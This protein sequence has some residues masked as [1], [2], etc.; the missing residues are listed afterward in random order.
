[1]SMKQ[2]ISW[3]SVLLWMSLIY[4]LS[5]Q[6]AA[7][8]TELSTGVMQVLIASFE[9]IFLFIN[10][11]TEWFHFLIRKGAHFTAYFILGILLINALR[12]SK[13][14]DTSAMIALLLSVLYAISDEVHQLFIPGRSGEVRDVLIDSA[15]A[16]VGISLYYLLAKIKAK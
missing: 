3:L 12:K 7:E 6:P 1:M 10:L 14:V 15:G 13:A 4:Y 2:V 11:E 5:H 8:S 9:A 16:A